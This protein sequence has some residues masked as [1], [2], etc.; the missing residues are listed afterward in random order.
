MDIFEKQ[1]KKTVAIFVVLE[2]LLFIINI[3]AGIVGAFLIWF[4]FYIL[5]KNE[6]NNKNDLT[7]KIAGIKEDMKS[8]AEDAIFNMPFP[9]VLTDEKGTVIWYNPILMKEISKKNEVGMEVDDLISG[10]HFE[11]FKTET[12]I[13]DFSLGDSSY[14]IYSNR[15]QKSDGKVLYLFYFVNND[16]TL[17]ANKNYNDAKIGMAYIYIDNYD[18]IERGNENLYKPM[19]LA[20]IDSKIVNYFTLNDAVIRRYDDDRY[21]AVYNNKTFEFLKNDK[22]S[23]LDTVREI[24]M[25]NKSPVT[26]S[27]G[28]SDAHVDLSDANDE[29]ISSIDL[30]LG[31]GGDQACVM[32][33][34]R[35]TF[36]GG[37][38]QAKEKRNRV[39]VRMI[40]NSLIRLIDQSEK[41]FIMGH[42]NPDMD[43]I[44]SAIG[45]LSGVLY[46]KK[47]AYL[48]LNES[49]A[50]IEL[51][52]KKMEDVEPDL[53]EHFIDSEKAL[54]LADKRTSLVIMTD[55]HRK[56]AAEE[57]RIFDY[58]EKA[59]IIDHHRKGTNGVENPVISYIEP[60]ASSASELVTEILGYMGKD[61][62]LSKF[63]AEC[64]MS[65][66]VVDTKNFTFQTGVRTFD[67]AA[68]LKRYGADMTDVKKYF[69][70]DI[71]TVKEKAKAI[72]N[73]EIY[74]ENLVIGILEN[75]IE[76]GTLISA[77]AADELLNVENIKASF[78]LVK[79]KDYIHI[80]ARSLGDISVQVIMEGL[81]G[82]GHL[83]SSATQIYDKSMEEAVEMLK[84]EID[85]YFETEKEK[86]NEDNI[87]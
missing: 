75:S 72:L 11:K 81:G 57:P 83:V 13:K 40:A 53:K 52:L 22:F 17:K 82:G 29:A 23:I 87:D 18:E 26:L 55:N 10:F 38:S 16:E 14:I 86:N 64:L 54:E 36:F 8:A 78:V 32:I 6:E 19:L 61:F 35:E 9:L 65:G 80:S 50:S 4:F 51:I 2:I 49:N 42:K 28:A 31:R 21:F 62:K 15:L 79:V 1:D 33:S 67:A 44:G 70:D 27:I 63:E 43:S 60:Y 76:N 7:E 85:K 68:T 3:Y 84:A 45:I 69:Q 77:Q 30:A 66:I 47:D 59:V 58:V 25:G 48:I 34:G 41:V 37:R 74:R 56:M 24:K 71:E 5:N 46:R 39:K 20:E 73:T 12:E